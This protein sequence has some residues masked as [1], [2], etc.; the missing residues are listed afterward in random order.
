MNRFRTPGR[1]RG[2]RQIA[3]TLVVASLCLSACET[4]M[5]TPIQ[6]AELTFDGLQP[7]AGTGMQRAWV[8]PDVSVAGYDRILPVAPR[9][10]YRTVRHGSSRGAGAVALDDKQKAR[11]L[12]LIR[13]EFI[14]ELGKSQYFRLTDEPGP[15]VLQLETALLDIVSY[16]GEAPAGRSREW[17]ASLGEATLVLQLRDSQS[18]E[19]LVRTADRRAFED[20][21]GGSRNTPVSNTAQVRRV[22]R[23]WARILRDRLDQMHEHSLK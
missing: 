19:T 16:V 21:S 10:E 5:P 13:A 23:R 17:V 4:P 6:G 9:V 11:L 8:R 3:L 7:V 12:E 22:A 20:A 14:D 2:Q 18:G 1:P 15:E